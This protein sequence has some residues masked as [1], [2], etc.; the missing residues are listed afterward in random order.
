MLNNINNDYHWALGLIEADG[1]IGFNCQNP[2]SPSSVKKIYTFQVKVSLKNYNSRAV[3][4]IK[5]IFSVGKIHKS[6][7]GMI[8]WKVSNTD[9]LINKVFPIFDTYPFKGK[10]YFDLVAT[11]EA[12][13]LYKSD[14]TWQEKHEILSILKESITCELRNISPIWYPYLEPKDYL[15]DPEPI[16]LAPAQYKNMVPSQEVLK[17]LISPSWLSGFIEGDG[18]FQIN[19]RLQAVFELGQKYNIFL[20]FAI[21]KFF[22]VPSKVK[23][24]TNLSYFSIS[25]KHPRVL[26]EVEKTVEKKLLGIKSFEFAVW[27][28]ARRTVLVTKK[29]KAS[30]ILNKIRLRL[31]K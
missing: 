21:H 18:S 24:T 7:D 15:I 10:K 22:N 9:I 1:Y 13:V 25:S 11:K 28:R 16:L 31:I 3:Y 26:D 30:L 5:S 17:T 6:S 20:V 14:R 19:N 23:I 29:E 2:K 27:R 4:R 12:I 8:T